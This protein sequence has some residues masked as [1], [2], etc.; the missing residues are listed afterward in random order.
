[1]IEVGLADMVTVAGDGLVTATVTVTVAFPPE[2]VA[3]AV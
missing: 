3:F 2:L 1:V